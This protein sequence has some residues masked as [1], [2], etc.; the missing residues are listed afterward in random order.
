MIQTANMDTV[1]LYIRCYVAFLMLFHGMNKVM[2]GIVPI[3]DLV[4]KSGLP[5][6]L[7]Y[8][9]YV[10]EIVAPLMLIVGVW[11]RVGASLII[12]NVLFCIGLAHSDA[13][14]KLNSTGGWAL[15]GEMVYIFPCLL[16]ILIGEGRYALIRGEKLKYQNNN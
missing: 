5:N 7:A 16:I 13:V 14:F 9:V 12:I 1:R 2:H 11:S 8:G 6:W 15:E 4:L 3:V 10:G